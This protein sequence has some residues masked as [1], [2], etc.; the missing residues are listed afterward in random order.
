MSKAALKLWLV[1]SNKFLN[2]F[3]F[4]SLYVLYF[5]SSCI[6]ICLSNRLVKSLINCYYALFIWDLCIS[7]IYNSGNKKT[8]INACLFQYFPLYTSIAL[9]V[10][11][12]QSFFVTVIVKLIWH[13]HRCSRISDKQSYV[14]SLG[15]FIAFLWNCNVIMNCVRM[16]LWKY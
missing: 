14:K 7:R 8:S 6:C 5:Y 16:S 13:E 4:K 9:R 12:L 10:S 15:K 1:K 11:L 3:F 2:F